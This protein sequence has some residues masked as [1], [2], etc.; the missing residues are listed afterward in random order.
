MIDC[1]S[2]TDTRHHHLRQHQQQQRQRQRQQQQQQQ[3]EHEQEQ[4]EKQ[5]QEEEQEV[6][7]PCFVLLQNLHPPT[8]Y[9][10]QKRLNI[11]QSSC[12]IEGKHPANKNS[13][14]QPPNV[15]APEPIGHVPRLHLFCAIPQH[16]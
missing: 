11:T 10:A 3:E 9:L 4:E 15:V 2:G 6:K 7:H 5:E 1:N 8:H 13:I 16:S 14:S 12:Q